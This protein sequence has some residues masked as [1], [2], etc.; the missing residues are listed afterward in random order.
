MVGVAYLTIFERKVLRYLQFRKGPNKVG[1]IG[2]LQPFRDGFLLKLLR[3]ERGRL[4]FKA[5]FIIYYICPL[6]LLVFILIFWL[7]LPWVTNIYSL[8]YSI[9]IVFIL[10]SLSGFMIIM[11]GWSSN[12]IFSLMGAIRFIAQSIS[13]EVRFMLIIFR[14]MILSES[15]SLVKNLA[16]LYM[17]YYIVLI[18]IFFCFFISILAEI[19]R[20]PMDLVDGES[21]LVSGFNVEYY[22]VEFALISLQNMEA[23]FFFVSLLYFYLLLI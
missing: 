19:N 2:L 23:L 10:M 3:K 13:Y 22:G 9:I 8:N 6:I 4:I 5:N 11:I 20:S 1:F 7:L 17:K 15:Y 12:S 16:V 21:E 14:I 18:S